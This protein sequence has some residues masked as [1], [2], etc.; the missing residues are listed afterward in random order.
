[1]SGC[2]DDGVI[3][4]RDRLIAD[5]IRTAECDHDFDP[6]Q[7]WTYN[8]RNVFDYCVKCRASINRTIREAQDV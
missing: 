7:S 3:S 8:E 6:A 2:E 5:R 1:M 4:E